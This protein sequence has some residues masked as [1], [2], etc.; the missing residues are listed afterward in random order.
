[1]NNTLV[2]TLNDTPRP[3][4]GRKPRHAERGQ[5]FTVYLTPSQRRVLEYIGA[6]AE[7]G[8]G[9]SAGITYLI[10][11]FAKELTQKTT[12]NNSSN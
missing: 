6:R 3:K 2:P 5:N 10:N 12:N 4:R 8:G 1:M 7:I 9:V 11:K